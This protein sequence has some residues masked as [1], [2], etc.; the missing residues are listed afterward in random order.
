MNAKKGIILGVVFASLI[1]GML[2]IQRA[3]PE[4][5]E[6]R[7]Y[8]EIKL[9]SPYKLEKRMG[10]LTI[11]NKSTG[12][13]EKPSSEEVLLRMDELDK[14]WGKKHLRVEHNDLIIM[15]ENNQTMVKIYIET[16]KEREFL[17]RFFGI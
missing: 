7:I 11:I 8:N 6:D 4:A 9:Y 5:K 10:G 1:L 14:Q 2:S 17:R 16:K 12:E 15:G 3:M 13:K